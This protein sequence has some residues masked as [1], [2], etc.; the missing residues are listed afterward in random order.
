MLPG[1]T[2]VPEALPEDAC[3]VELPAV[4]VRAR[5]AVAWRSQHPD[6]PHTCVRLH[7]VVAPDA[8]P[9]LNSHTR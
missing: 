5:Q 6:L 8:K 4:Q 7:R 2:M 9:K 1:Y 3:L